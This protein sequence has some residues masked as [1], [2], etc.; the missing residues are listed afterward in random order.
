MWG[1]VVIPG[2]SAAASARPRQARAA[3]GAENDFPAACAKKSVL[4]SL[5]GYVRHNYSWHPNCSAKVSPWRVPASASGST[6]QHG[7]Q[8]RTVAPWILGPPICVLKMQNCGQIQTHA[9]L[10][11]GEA[12]R[13]PNSWGASWALA[14]EAAFGILSGSLWGSFLGRPCG[15]AGAAVSNTC[16]PGT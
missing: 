1:Q 11:S 9:G 6:F 13:G 8:F 14:L 7:D 3:Q 5:W 4:V 16:F 10:G 12:R 15:E 2:R